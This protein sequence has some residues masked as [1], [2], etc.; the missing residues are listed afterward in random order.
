MDAITVSKIAE[1]L[2]RS[3]LSDRQILGFEADSRKILPGFVFFALQGETVDGHDFLEDVRLKGAALAVVSKSYVGKVPGLELIYVDNVLE[4]LHKIASYRM[5]IGNMRCVAVTGSVGKTTTKEFI[6]TILEGAFSVGKTPGNAN[7]QVGLPL[8]ILNMKGTPEIFVAEMGMSQKGEIAAL[9]SIAP[10]DIAVVTK[11]ALAHALYFPGGLED[12]AA[13]KAEILLHP[14]TKKSFLH[15][16]VGSFVAFQNIKTHQPIFYGLNG[17]DAMLLKKEGGFAIRTLE[18]V[19]KE[20]SLPFT[21]LHLAENFLAAAL[22]AREL[23]MEWESI[24][25][26]AKY[27]SSYKMRF[28][29]IEKNGVTYINDAYNANPESMKAALENLPSPRTGRNTIAALGEMRELGI[30]SKKSHQEVGQIAAQHADVLFCLE[31]DALYMAEEFAKSGRPAFYFTSILELKK[32][33][34]EYIQD[35]DVVLLKASNSLKMWQVL[36]S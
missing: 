17:Q 6:A 29:K 1:L 7:S 11:V 31:G 34:H 19:T 25:E 20:F 27:L 35:G 8:G 16:Q 3:S 24:F 36:D 28:E 13:A 22:V 32:A 33:L 12:V 2:G 14:K 9:L 5:E 4:S 15:A 23:G 21:A 30:F 10:P 26:R 18:G